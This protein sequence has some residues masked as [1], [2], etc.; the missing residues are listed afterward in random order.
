MVPVDGIASH[1]H[2]PGLILIEWS[3]Y[4]G[5]TLVGSGETTDLLLPVGEHFVTLRVMDD[6][7]NESA[8]TTVVNVLPQGYPVVESLTPSSGDSD[9]G[10]NVTISGFG[11]DFS[12]EETVV[13]FGYHTLTG[14]S[15]ITVVDTNTIVVLSVPAES[16]GIPVS[17]TVTTPI[18]EPSNPG[19]YT[20]INGV[21]IAWSRGLLYQM[22]V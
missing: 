6:G 14:S 3:W 16:L 2:A 11:F 1:T 7:G 5:N 22:Y 19:T 9:G 18:G 17:V 20:Y 8:E 4:E 13:H 12:E 21:S 15:E 10:N